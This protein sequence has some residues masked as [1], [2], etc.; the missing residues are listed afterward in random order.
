L[1]DK[2]LL[3]TTLPRQLKLLALLLVFVLGPFAGQV[4]ASAPV[5]CCCAGVEFQASGVD[6]CH[7]GDRHGS[8]GCSFE[9]APELPQALLEN[10]TVLSDREQP[11][12][13]SVLSVFDL[14]LTSAPPERVALVPWTLRWVLPSS[15]PLLAFDLALPPP[16]CS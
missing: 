8:S 15:P 13:V 16:V 4:V 6:G 10:G 9:C 12:C 5:R 2:P 3:M 7:C 14:I 11:L 1:L